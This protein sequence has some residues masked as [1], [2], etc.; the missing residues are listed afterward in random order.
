M[1]GFGKSQALLRIFGLRR[2]DANTN[3]S[4]LVTTKPDL[5]YNPIAKRPLF[6]LPLRRA[7]TLL[8]I[9]SRSKMDVERVQNEGTRHG[10]LAEVRPLPR[11]PAYHGFRTNKK[12]AT[13]K[14][15]LGDRLHAHSAH[16]FCISGGWGP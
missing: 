12:A 10:M 2:G 11:S 9:L 16:T 14:I 6:C 7:R 1:I 15:V 8:H 4:K 13:S 3:F 5:S